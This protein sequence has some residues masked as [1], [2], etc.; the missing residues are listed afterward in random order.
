[1]LNKINYQSILVSMGIGILIGMINIFFLNQNNSFSEI[2][3]T[4]FISSIIGLFIGGTTEIFTSLLPISIANP[5]SFVVINALI[6]II[7]TICVLIAIDRITMSGASDILLYRICS[8]A[9]VI[10]FI[11]N[12]FEYKLYK[13]VNEKLNTY[14]LNL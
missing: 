14:K 8:I 10:I 11:A 5:K 9:A 7:I 4:L 12:Y 3:I 13:R 2:L 6:G 1:M